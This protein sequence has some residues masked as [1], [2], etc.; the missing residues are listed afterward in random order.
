MDNNETRCGVN[1]WLFDISADQKPSWTAGL[2]R[3][4]ILLIEVG[5]D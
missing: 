3:N 5:L 4:P 2:R 1:N